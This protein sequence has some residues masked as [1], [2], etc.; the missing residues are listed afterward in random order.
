MVE[1]TNTK[2]ETKSDQEAQKEGA[3]ERAT[4]LA[5]VQASLGFYFFLAFQSFVETVLGF[6][7]ACMFTREY[8]YLASSAPGTANA[9]ASLTAF[10]AV[11]EAVHR[12]EGQACQCAHRQGISLEMAH[13]GAKTSRRLF[14]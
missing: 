3:K 2:F 8:T 12:S 9:S 13:A 14:E 4:Q 7:F 10:E 6:I 5:K 11:V 1:T